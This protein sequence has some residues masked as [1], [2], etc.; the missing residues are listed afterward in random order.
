MTGAGSSQVI[1]R[2]AHGGETPWHEHDSSLSPNAN[3]NPGPLTLPKM[4]RIDQGASVI[5][6]ISPLSSHIG[7]L[8]VKRR[9]QLL[10]NKLMTMPKEME[11]STPS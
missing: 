1:R 4:A 5:R 9:S 6:F 10:P 7:V 11:P 8:A 3:P 2:S